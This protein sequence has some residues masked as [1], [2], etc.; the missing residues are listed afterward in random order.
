[1]P[2]HSRRSTTRVGSGSRFWT[3]VGRQSLEGGLLHAAGDRQTQTVICRGLRHPRTHRDCNA[4]EDTQLLDHEICELSARMLTTPDLNPSY[5]RTSKARRIQKRVEE[6]KTPSCSPHPVCL[7]SSCLV[8][9]E[10]DDHCAFL[11]QGHVSWIGGVL[12]WNECQ[13]SVEYVCMPQ[14]TV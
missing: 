3:D 10:A 1:M 14:Y 5:S 11:S 9:H 7:A 6:R 4:K 8:V 12:I 13:T 2:D